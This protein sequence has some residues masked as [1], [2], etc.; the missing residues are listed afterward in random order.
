MNKWLNFERKREMNMTTVVWNGFFIRQLWNTWK[1]SIFENKDLMRKVKNMTVG[2]SLSPIYLQISWFFLIFFLSPNIL[3]FSTNILFIRKY[4]WYFC[5][6]NLYQRS[7]RATTFYIER[8]SHLGEI[9]CIQITAFS[10][11]VF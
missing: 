2:C 7:L 6:N 4:E 9:F 10:P 5:R 11:L 3:I 8:C 1:E